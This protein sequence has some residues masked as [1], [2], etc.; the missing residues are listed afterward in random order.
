MET[1]TKRVVIAGGSGFLGQHLEREL[2]K[3]GYE[4]MIL[5]RSPRRS[6]EIGWDGKAL[7]TWAKAVDGAYGVINLTGKSV[8][9]RYTPENRRE[10]IASR[11]DS[12]TV[13]NEAI[14]KSEKPPAVLI[15]ASSLAIYGNPGAAV[16]DESTPP[17]SGFSPEV[18]IQWERAF[19]QADLPETRRVVLR[20]GF[21]L[22]KD[23]GALEPL[24]NLTRFFLGGT[25]GSGNQYISWLHID[26]L[27]QIFIQALEDDRYE[28]IYNATSPV[29]VT[30][31]EFMRSLRHTLNRPWSPPTP[32][33]F[34]HIGAFLMRTEPALA[35][36]G[37]R[38][39]PRRLQEQGFQF[40]HTNLDQAL[41]DLL[42]K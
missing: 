40:R 17:A 33:P 11:V 4:V 12:V 27:N 7:G 36:E 37:R 22:A 6:N 24:V 41:A 20:I 29:P 19:Y 32:A 16:C 14:L 21:A 5:T 31:R 26:D 2:V 10:I 38:C 34:V 13:M 23:G 42:G 18:C 30:N 1:T 9:C 25:V 39:L 35:L 3:R 28:G 8:N 15:Q